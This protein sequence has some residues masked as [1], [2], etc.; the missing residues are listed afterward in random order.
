MKTDLFN[1]A[2]NGLNARQKAAVDAIEGPVIVLAG[3]GTGKTSILTLRIANILRRTATPPDG[4][5]AL[6]FTESGVYSMR[7]RLVEII[8]SAGYRVVISTF[9][10]FCNDLIQHYPEEFPRIIGSKAAA[11][12][13]QIE[14]IEKL[15]DRSDFEY[16]KPYGNPYYYLRAALSSIKNLK[17]ENISPETF[18]KLIEK[19]KNEIEGGIL[20]GSDTDKKGK[21]AS[22]NALKALA[23]NLE[24]ALLYENYES[25]LRKMSLYDFEDMILE[26]ITAFEKSKDFLLSQQERFLYILA[27]EHQD[28]NES[29]NRLLELL[30]SFHQNPNIFIVGDEKQAIYRFQG[31]SLENFLHFKRIYPNARVISLTENYRS[32]Q[33]ILNASHEVIEKG[34]GEHE[35]LVGRAKIPDLKETIRLMEFRRAETEMVFLARDIAKKISG[36]VKPEDIAVLYRVNGDAKEIAEA[37]SREGVVYT[38]ESDE[39]MLRDPFIQKFIALLRAVAHVGDDEKLFR[40]LSCDFMNVEPLDLYKTLKAAHERRISL[41]DAVS[42]RNVLAAYGIKNAKTMGDA[43]RKISLWAE[44]SLNMSLV[45]IAEKIALQSGFTTDLVSRDNSALL[46]RK[47]DAF[48]EEI[49]AFGSSRPR[50]G[51]SDFLS[52]I[53][54][55]VRHGVSL[56]AATS[57]VFNEGAR[58]MTSHKAKGREFDHVYIVK[59]TDG[60]FGNRREIDL[61]KLPIESVA[62]SSSEKN[63]DER[64]LFYVAMTRARK[65]LTISY[66]KTKESGRDVLPSEFL[67]S[68]DPKYIESVDTTKFEELYLKK[69]EKRQV[70]EVASVSSAQLTEKTYLRKL[71]LD[72]GLNITAINSYL[73]CPW[74]YFFNN[75]IRI[76]RAQKPHQ[77]FGTAVH[78]SLR[79]C[80]ESRN[81]GESMTSIEVSE[82]FKNYLRKLPLSESDFRRFEKR[83]SAALQG[84]IEK[85]AGDSYST[86]NEF[87]IAGVFVSIDKKTDVLLRG[88]LDKVEITV[89][90]GNLVNVVDYKTGAPKSRRHITGE[91]KDSGGEVKR[92][93]DFYK[94]LLERY[95][96]GKYRMQ[97]GKIDFV[98]P[99]S[100][101]KYRCEELGGETLDSDGILET[102]K[103]VAKEIYDLAFWDKKCN[104]KECEHCDLREMLVQRKKV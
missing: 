40:A 42:D 41:W 22:E 102:T 101:G 7:K 29:Q 50:S 63:N 9:H 18:R 36:G 25:E 1:G 31:A 93:L 53:D 95:E 91:T 52:Y 13:D 24:L 51:I 65:S 88:K 26:V 80:F 79:D 33:K 8:G 55:C 94:L 35:K 89:P 90:G 28:A 67:S 86:I 4:V 2:Y 32:A 16:I 15:I 59:T 85:T 76:P 103:Q 30:A 84:Y 82:R 38:V 3:P 97:S 83:G 17:R 21:L 48:F 96:N 11:A 78:N 45:E 37:L 71:F 39:D 72:Q 14:I 99:D 100:S 77:L 27:D 68:I 44:D 5:L 87:S 58:L 92:Q 57:T 56:Q 64:R 47:F 62:Y 19:R 6:T 69:N 66:S 49:A 74:D 75:L 20:S 23:K 43:V 81:R 98:E 104:E 10:G 60:H 54:L 34:G 46:L 73:K 12:I 70:K 61:F